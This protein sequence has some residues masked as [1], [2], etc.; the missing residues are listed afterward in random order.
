MHEIDSKF[1]GKKKKYLAVIFP[2]DIFDRS[3][4]LALNTIIALAA[5]SPLCCLG[6]SA[7]PENPIQRSDRPGALEAVHNFGSWFPVFPLGQPAQNDQQLWPTVLNSVWHKT[8]IAYFVSVPL[9][10]QKS[11]PATSIL[12]LSSKQK[13]A[14]QL[15]WI[16]GQLRSSNI[17]SYGM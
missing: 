4:T 5:L 9:V 3:M 10:S 14:P 11:K 7:L 16:A 1:E 6:C 2:P 12:T 8:E 13:V 17:N 15:P